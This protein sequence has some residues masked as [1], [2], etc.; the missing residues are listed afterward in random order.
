ME[1]LPSFAVVNDPTYPGIAEDYARSFSTLRSLP[2]DVFLA[3]HAGFFKM[4]GKRSRL[5]AGERPNPFIDREG[6]LRFVER[7][8]S[9]YRERIGRERAGGP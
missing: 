2:C 9:R 7:A 6:Y 3:S 1:S 8:E 4:D 5:D